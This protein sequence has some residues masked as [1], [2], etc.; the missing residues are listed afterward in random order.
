MKMEVCRIHYEGD[1][2]PATLR[3]GKGSMFRAPQ[4]KAFR[5]VV[6]GLISFNYNGTVRNDKLY[7]LRIHMRQNVTGNKRRFYRGDI[8]NMTKPILDSATRIIWADDSQ[9]IDLHITLAKESARAGFDAIFYE[10]ADW[11]NYRERVECFN[12]GKEF[13][14]LKSQIKLS[15][16]H[17]CSVDCR[18]AYQRIKKNCLYCEKE[19]TFR[20]SAERGTKFCSQNCY[21][22]Y[23]R[24]HPEKYKH[25]INNLRKEEK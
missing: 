23:M 12:C 21:W 16:S 18:L 17:F 7:G 8:D 13:L 15:K 1:L 11:H 6:A 5:E 22:D 19:F 4:Y 10:L 25:L 9:L 24:K 14:K 20:R 2:V 3:C